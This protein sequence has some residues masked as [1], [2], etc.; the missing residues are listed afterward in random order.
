MSTPSKSKNG[1]GSK[2]PS[3]PSATA[4]KFFGSEVDIKGKFIF[5]IWRMLTLINLLI[6]RFIFFNEMFLG[7]Q[8]VLNPPQKLAEGE[9]MPEPAGKFLVASFPEATL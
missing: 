4:E 1:G 2:K 5:K 7:I 3:P 6:F 9:K 8:G